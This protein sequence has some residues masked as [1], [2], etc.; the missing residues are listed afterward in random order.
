MQQTVYSMPQH[1][2]R[3][4]TPRT[5]PRTPPRNSPPRPARRW[6]VW[7]GVIGLALAAVLGSPAN[8]VANDKAALNEAKKELED[9]FKNDNGPGMAAAVEK[10]AA[11]DSVDAVRTLCRLE[12]LGPKEAYLATADAL[13]AV[14]DEKQLKAVVDEYK[15]AE[16]KKTWK[17][18]V[19]LIDALADDIPGPADEVFED[20]V[21][22]R[23]AKV[24]LAAVRALASTEEPTR[25]H[26]ELLI[27]ALRLSEKLKDIGT[28]H[29]E[30]RTALA[31]FTQERFKPHEEWLEWFKSLPEDYQ[32]A[33]T[34]Q[35]VD[36]DH[37][38]DEEDLKYYEVPVTSRRMLFIIDTSGSMFAKIKY[39]TVSEGGDEV[40][41]VT[42]RMEL[43]KKELTQLLRKLPPFSG[44]NVMKFDTGTGSWKRNLIPWSERNIDSACKY[45][46]AMD[47]NGAT[48]AN[49]ALTKALEDNLDAD[50]IYFLSDGAPTDAPVEQILPNIEKLNRFMRVKIH[51]IGIG[52]GAQ[53]LL[54]PLAEQN[55]GHYQVIEA[56]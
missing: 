6:P 7:L 10:I 39:K 21:Q 9:A 29:L 16:R 51:T 11:T 49:E 18:Q 45:V 27:E 15:K 1:T 52:Q 50:T 31:I 40:E 13:A 17:R 30:A 14:T 34:E 47:P 3:N 41:E 4:A 23:H 53:N 46:A 26:V 20:A 44:F 35:E 24:R 8:A 42:T 43:A 32:P 25:L 22:D 19:L 55:E 48:A 2:A 56:Q 5:P 12:E 28:P 38:I 37:Q 54:K 33:I 36:V